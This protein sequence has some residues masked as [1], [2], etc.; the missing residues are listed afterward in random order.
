[1]MNQSTSVFEVSQ[2]EAW[3]V[4]GEIVMLI[5]ATYSVFLENLAKRND[6]RINKAR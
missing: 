1:M 5:E 6:L 2:G 3:E 4:Y